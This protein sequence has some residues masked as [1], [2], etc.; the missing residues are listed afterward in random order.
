M[1]L[2]QR[3]SIFNLMVSVNSIIKNV[4]QIKNR[5][6]KDVNMSVKIIVHAKKIIVG[7]LA[8][9]FVRIAIIQKVLLI[10]P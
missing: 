2:K 4:I 9:I 10:I 3:E 7:I 5:I 1:N 8:N 6:M